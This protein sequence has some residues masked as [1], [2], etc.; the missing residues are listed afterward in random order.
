MESKKSSKQ[1][2]QTRDNE[3]GTPGFAHVVNGFV[4]DKQVTRGEGKGFG[5]GPLKVNGKIFA[6]MTSKHKFVVKLPKDRV[7]DLVRTN[8]GENFAP[9]AARLMKEWLVVFPANNL[10]VELAREAHRYVKQSAE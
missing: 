4:E 3:G 8:L 2:N 1:T 5:S 6:M 10:W 7:D 9:R